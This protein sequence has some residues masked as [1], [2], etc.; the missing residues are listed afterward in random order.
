MS[1]LFPIIYWAGR[2]ETGWP[3]V[4]LTGAPLSLIIKTQSNN[5][6]VPYSVSVATAT[7]ARGTVRPM[8]K[9]MTAGNSVR[10]DWQ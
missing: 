4:Q 6:I 8:R 7:R 10:P 9:S 5:V 3:K 1:G 2:G